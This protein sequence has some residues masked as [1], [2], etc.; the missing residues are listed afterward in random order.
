MYVKLTLLCLSPS[1][2]AIKRREADERRLA[3]TRRQTIAALSHFSGRNSH[4]MQ[5]MAERDKA[6]EGSGSLWQQLD[7]Y[8]P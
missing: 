8:G 4:P 5:T 1:I 3:C 6:G 7:V 2:S